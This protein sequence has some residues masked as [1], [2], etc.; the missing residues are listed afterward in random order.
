VFDSSRLECQGGG[1]KCRLTEW[2]FRN[3]KALQHA[4]HLRTFVVRQEVYRNELQLI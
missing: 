1:V 2:R 4:Y 3:G